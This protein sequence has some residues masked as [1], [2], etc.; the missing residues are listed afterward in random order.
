MQNTPKICYAENWEE[1]RLIR[2]LLDI[3]FYNSLEFFWVSSQV[4][5]FWLGIVIIQ[6]TLL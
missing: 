6:L 2:L 3:Y 4:S 1:Q 5:F